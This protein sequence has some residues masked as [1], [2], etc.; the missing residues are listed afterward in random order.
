M[1]KLLALWSMFLLML[2]NSMA[3]AQI[4]AELY[5]WKLRKDTSGIKVFTS[6]VPGS[7]FLAVSATMVIEA[8]PE[9]VA[10]LIMDLD[11]CS[12]WAKLCRQAY[13]QERISSTE[14]FVYSRNDIPFP[15]RDRDAV[16]HV[17]WSKD[18]ET[19][20]LSMTSRATKGRLPKVKGVIRIE[21]ALAKWRFTP[22]ADNTL[23]V[24]S[25]AHV[26]PASQM[27]LWL[28]NSL[29]VGSPYKTLKGIRN[30]LLLVFQNTYCSRVSIK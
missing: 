2:T 11:N 4:D 16:T 18:S 27:P 25:F 29:L 1:V 5:E 12:S 20:V 13:I 6:K 15:G 24:E 23:L 10:S 7:K 19:G 28:L 8:T 22:Q 9:S 30:R 14:T 26:N 21:Q 3:Q 17:V